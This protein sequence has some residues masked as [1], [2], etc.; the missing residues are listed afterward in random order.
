MYGYFYLDDHMLVHNE[1]LRLNC[2]LCEKEFFSDKT[3]KL[4]MKSVHKKHL[5]YVTGETQGGRVQR[6][7]YY[8][9]PQSFIKMF[10]FVGLKTLRTFI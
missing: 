4:H 2:D 6:D 7:V 10:L 1:E 9:C 8:T 5:R 3:L